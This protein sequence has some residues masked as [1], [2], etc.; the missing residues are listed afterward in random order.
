MLDS[1]PDVTGPHVECVCQQEKRGEGSL[2]Q[3][4]GV[5]LLPPSPGVPEMVWPRA[6]SPGARRA[7]L[8]HDGRSR[9]HPEK[10]GRALVTLLLRFGLS[11]TVLRR[12]IETLSS[13]YCSC[14]FYLRPGRLQTHVPPG[15]A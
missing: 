11:S 5:L 13:H 15:E 3:V 14:F 8:A 2:P 6:V 12:D 7:S 10:S 4:C 1:H 9:S